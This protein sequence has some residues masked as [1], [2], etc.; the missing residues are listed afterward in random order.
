NLFKFNGFKTFFRIISLPINFDQGFPFYGRSDSTGGNRQD[1]R[2]KKERPTK[3]V[4]GWYLALVH[5]NL[6]LMTN[7][8]SEWSE[9]LLP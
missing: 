7:Q 6:Q 2:G 3:C 5:L 8:S 1:E 9:K 4:R